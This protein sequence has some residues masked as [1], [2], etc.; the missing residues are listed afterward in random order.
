MLKILKLPVKLA[1]GT[2]GNLNTLWATR[3]QKGHLN[4]DINGDMPYEPRE[5]KSRDQ[6]N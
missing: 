5:Y 2:H 1:A 4:G 3:T 6:L